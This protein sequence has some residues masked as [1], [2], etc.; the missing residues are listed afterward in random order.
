MTK[1]TYL[2]LS[3]LGNWTKEFIKGKKCFFTRQ[4]R[5]S[6]KLYIIRGVDYLRAKKM[7][8]VKLSPTKG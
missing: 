7:T 2:F 5:K 3:F 6:R 1:P 4:R 8:L